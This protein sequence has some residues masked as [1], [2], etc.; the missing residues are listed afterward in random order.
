MIMNFAKSKTLF[1]FFGGADQKVVWWF[2]KVVWWFSLEINVSGGFLVW[3]F[4][5]LM[6]YTGMHQC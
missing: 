2:Q 4:Q 1:P 6:I 3:W 5:N